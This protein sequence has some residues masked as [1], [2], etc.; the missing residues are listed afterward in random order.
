MHPQTPPSSRKTPQHTHFQKH[1]ESPTL[2]STKR[3][4][5][6]ILIALAPQ[7]NHQ[8]SAKTTS[9]HMYGYRKRLTSLPQPGL[10][11][12]DPFRRHYYDISQ[13]AIVSFRDQHTKQLN[14][15]ATPR[16]QPPGKAKLSSLLTAGEQARTRPLLSRRCCH[17]EKKNAVLSPNV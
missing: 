10:W 7:V 2:G 6:A 8:L 17:Q 15:Q 1:Q 13:D 3:T 16:R 4:L 14:C 9:M 5:I 11:H 12:R